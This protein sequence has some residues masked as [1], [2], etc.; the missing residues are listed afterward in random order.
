MPPKRQLSLPGLGI[1][2]M[3]RQLPSNLH[4]GLLC[5]DKPNSKSC[6]VIERSG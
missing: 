2:L 4:K 3:V 6:W 5:W 1:L